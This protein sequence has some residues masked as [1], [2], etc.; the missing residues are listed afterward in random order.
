MYKRILI[1]AILII[2]LGASDI[3]KK[4]YPPEQKL[5]VVYIA[6]DDLNRWIG[7]LGG[8]AKTPNIDKLASQGMLFTNAHCVVPACNPS[9]VSILTGLRPETTGQFKNEGNFRE[10]KGN[11]ERITMPQYL[12]ANGYEAVAVGKVFHQPRGKS[13]NPHPF[14]DDIS[15]DYQYKNTSSCTKA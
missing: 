15:W 9:R 6:V 4:A 7:A 8:Q 14:S 1:F 10:I 13:E 5:N 12:R 2:I 11:S 3:N